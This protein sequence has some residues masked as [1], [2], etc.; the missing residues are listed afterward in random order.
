M[1]S[2]SPSSGGFDNNTQSDTSFQFYQA[3]RYIITRKNPILLLVLGDHSLCI[4]PSA[5]FL[6]PIPESIHTK[7][8]CFSNDGVDVISDFHSFFLISENDGTEVE[9][10]SAQIP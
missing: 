4:P 5:L 8:G 1:K 3:N 7:R 2:T 6:M 9:K 10:N